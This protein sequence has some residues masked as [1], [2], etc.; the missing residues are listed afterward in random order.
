MLFQLIGTYRANESSKRNARE[1]KK[2]VGYGGEGSIDKDSQNAQIPSAA[3]RQRAWV[4]RRAGEQEK[5]R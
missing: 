5:K 3:W 4:D 1:R 2:E